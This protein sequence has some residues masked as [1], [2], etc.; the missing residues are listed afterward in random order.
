MKI[1]LVHVGILL[2]IRED[3][4]RG[5][6]CVQQLHNFHGVVRVPGAVVGEAHNA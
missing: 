1:H 3:I 5:V 4:K 6:D 2:R